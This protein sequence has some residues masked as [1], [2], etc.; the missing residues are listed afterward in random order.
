MTFESIETEWFDEDALRLPD[1]KVGRVNFGKGRSYIRINDG[2]ILE[3]PLRLYTSLTTAIGSCAPMEQPLLEWH[4]KHG[5][6]ESERLTKVAQMYG[7]LMHLE[8]GK[9]LKE[10]V[11]D[12]DTTEAIVENYTSE[13]DFWEVEC[14]DWGMKLK[15]DMAAFIQFFIDYEVVP[16]GIEY[17]LLSEKGFGTLIDLVCKITVD[18]KG[19]WGELYKT[20]DKKGTPKE[21]TERVQKI[22]IINF[23]SGRKGF[24]RSNG[25]Q[26]ECERQLWE[27]NFPD[28]PIDMAMNWAPNEWTSNPGYHVK[29]WKGD[30]CQEEVD[31]V[32]MLAKVRYASKAEN[33]SY[34]NIT[35]VVST[36]DSLYAALTRESIAEYCNRKFSST[37]MPEKK[38]IRTQQMQAMPVTPKTSFTAQPMPI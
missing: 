31:A 23:K 21:T 34:L 15:Y 5:L 8:I 26:I 9:F 12:F 22:A 6:Q 27:E 24:F 10:K 13:N 19:F 28:M 29:D 4:C 36:A 35:G 16:L 32:L 33:K 14:K 11:Y 37:P 1:Y 20:G 2:G 17:V 30:I 7:T 25:I 38:N 18:V 3:S